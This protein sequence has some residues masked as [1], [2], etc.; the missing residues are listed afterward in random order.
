MMANLPGGWI[1]Y[2]LMTDD[3]EDAARFYAAALDWSV[4]AFPGTEAM[5]EGGYH[6]FSAPD[7]QG[8]G[9]M[10]RRPEAGPP[11]GW[12]GYIG[13][14][15]V[16]AVTASIVAAGGAIHMPPT[17]MEGVGRMAMVADPQGATFY[18]MR[19]ASEEDSTAFQRMAIG[20][21]DWNE[22]RTG[23]DQAALAFYTEQFGWTR[24]G[25]LPMG[26]LGDYSFV[27][28]DGEVI[29][30]I[31]RTPPDAAPGWGFFFRV[32]QIDEA[33]DR[34]TT[35]GGTIAHGPQEVPGGDF[36]AYVADPQGATFGVVGHR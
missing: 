5:M 25:A 24:E 28:H 1:W 15:D 18:L 17:D 16:D 9:G 34:I 14:D 32:G 20:H 36:V 6:I 23:D 12:L 31:M 19:G 33:V 29:G 35:A 3:V 7:G 2:E 8:V 22:L 27:A 30:A 11:P 21:G 26:P 4:A 10:M 13:V